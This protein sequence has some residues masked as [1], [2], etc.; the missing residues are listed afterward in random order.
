MT[1]TSWYQWILAAALIALCGIAVAMAET[2]SVNVENSGDEVRLKIDG[3]SEVIRVDD[4]AAGEERVFT[5]GDRTIVVKRVN[6]H[7]E[8]SMDGDELGGRHHGVHSMDNFVWVSKDEDCEIDVESADGV[9]KIVVMSARGAESDEDVDLFC[10]RGEHEGDMV[11]DIDDIREKIEAGELEGIE[12][13]DIDIDIADEHVMVLG[14]D[15]NGPHPIV[16]KGHAFGGGDVV[17]YRC[18]ETGS[19]LIVNKDDAIEDAYIDPAT[20]CLMERVDEPEVHVV[21][22]RKRIKRGEGE[23]L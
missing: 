8:L 9:R 5:A 11:I 6:D 22:I 10:L 17:R 2:V 15:E 16:I 19:E 18:E 21:K 13:L 14:A 12:E 23:D 1:R 7:L 4:L 20:G 3:V